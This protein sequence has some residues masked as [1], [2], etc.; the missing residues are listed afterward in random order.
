MFAVES[1]TCAATGDGQGKLRK[2]VNCKLNLRGGVKLNRNRSF[3]GKKSMKSTKKPRQI[4][5]LTT[6]STRK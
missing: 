2:N 1:R 5:E 6:A 4:G 3:K